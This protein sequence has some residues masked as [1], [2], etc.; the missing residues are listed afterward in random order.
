MG[1]EF[2]FD[3][4]GGVGLAGG[5]QV[6]DSAADLV[7]AVGADDIGDADPVI[8]SRAESSCSAGCFHHSPKLIP[9][10]V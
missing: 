6:G 2:V 8:G 10:A 4:V 5:V 7:E 3:G 1:V 9:L